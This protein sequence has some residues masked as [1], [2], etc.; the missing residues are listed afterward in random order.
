LAL[1][2]DLAPLEELAPLEDGA[3]IFEEALL[4]IARGLSARST[5]LLPEV[6]SKEPARSSLH[7]P[8]I[9]KAPQSDV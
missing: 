4:R 7:P 2:K 9:V 3:L 5:G 8:P 6:S 1:F